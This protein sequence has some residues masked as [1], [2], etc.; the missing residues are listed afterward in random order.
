[1]E[2]MDARYVEPFRYAGKKEAAYQKLIGL[3]ASQPRARIVV[4]EANYL[5]AEFRSAVL[6]FVDDVEFL[7]SAEQ[8]VIDVRSA[9]RV[10]HYDFGTN[11][12]RVEAL[13]T[14]WNEEMG[15]H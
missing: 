11:R 7:L 13:R 6:R 4:K 1:M 9:S 15:I 8:P 14:Q 2:P 3:I 12:R 10:G 5:K